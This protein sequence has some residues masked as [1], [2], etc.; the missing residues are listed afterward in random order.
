MPAMKMHDSEGY[1]YRNPI[2]FTDMA[3]LVRI[4]V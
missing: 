1:A 4:C 3:Q 2:V